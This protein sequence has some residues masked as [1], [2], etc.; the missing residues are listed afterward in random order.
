MII[1]KLQIV[2]RGKRLDPRAA[3]GL[4]RAL[5]KRRPVCVCKHP[6]VNFIVQH[7]DRRNNRHAGFQNFRIE[8]VF[9]F[10]PRKRKFSVFGQIFDVII[11]NRTGALGNLRSHLSRQNIVIGKHNVRRF[12]LAVRQN[13]QRLDLHQRQIARNIFGAHLAHFHVF[14]I[15][16]HIVNIQLA[17]VQSQIF[18]LQPL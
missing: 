8:F 15:H 5:A 1:L 6:A 18:Q 13:V 16:I 12:R 7:A 10:P 4:C 17:S 14:Q 9:P 2:R 3:S 11:V